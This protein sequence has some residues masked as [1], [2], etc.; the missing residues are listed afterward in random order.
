MVDTEKLMERY[1]AVWNER[2]AQ[3]RHDLAVELWAEDGVYVTGANEH[4]GNAAIEAAVTTAYNDF[5]SQGFTFRLAGDVA[6]HHQGVK[7]V[8]H[9]TPEGSDEAVAIG[10]EFLLIGEN[11]RITHDYQFMELLPGS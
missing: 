11:G 8:W 9:M 5:L 10:H 7:F 2:D 4:R 3:Q 1:S 6:A